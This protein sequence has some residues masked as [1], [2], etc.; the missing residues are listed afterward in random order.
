MSMTNRSTDELWIALADSIERM[1]NIL[2]TQK[3][4]AAGTVGP[5]DFNDRLE[6]MI[7][8]VETMQQE[9]NRYDKIWTEIQNRATA[10]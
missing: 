8:A 6:K 9:R 10:R 1:S 3:A 7:Y 4:I 2:K 5:R